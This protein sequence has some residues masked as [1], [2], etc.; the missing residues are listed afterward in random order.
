MLTRKLFKVFNQI[1]FFVVL[2]SISV[3]AALIDNDYFTTDTETSLDW[4]DVTGT[5]NITINYVKSQMG[6]GGTYE[7]WRYATGAEVFDFWTHAGGSGIYEG[8]SVENNGLFNNLSLLWGTT[9]GTPESGYIAVAT[10]D[11]VNSTSTDVHLAMLS[12]WKEYEETSEMD[13]A[14]V[15]WHMHVDFAYEHEGHALVRDTATVP[16]P[17]SSGLIGF[18]VLALLA[19]RRRAT[20]Q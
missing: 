15:G 3:D 7:G 8:Y 18:G 12:D 11:L 14:Y 9:L 19:L 20:N 17:A 4:L 16:E 5:E 2:S 10:S 6:I 1:G 13:R